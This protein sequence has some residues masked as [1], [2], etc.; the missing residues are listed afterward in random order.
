MSAQLIQTWRHILID[1]TKPWVLFNHGTCVVLMQPQ[2]DIRQQAVALMREW[3]PVRAGSPAG[4]FSTITLRDHPGWVVT[5]HHDD[6]LTYVGPDELSAD[7]RDD[8][9]IGLFGRSKRHRDASELEV[10]HIE[11]KLNAP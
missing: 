10:I 9:T 8:L 2:A 11:D 1:E 6:I 5:S 4:D 3:G 7:G